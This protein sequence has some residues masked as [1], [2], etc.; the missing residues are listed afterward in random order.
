MHDADGQFHT[1]CNT[2]SVELEA[3]SPADEAEVRALLVEHHRRTNSDVAQRLLA[4]WE[5]SARTFVKV[6]PL[7]YRQAL[8]AQAPE[9]RL[10]RAVGS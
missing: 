3:L 1:R 8:A 7:D 9:P 10:P 2:G 6:M 4:S 5:A